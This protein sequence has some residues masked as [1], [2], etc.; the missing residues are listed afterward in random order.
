MLF[1]AFVYLLHSNLV[2]ETNHII[3]D[4]V[5]PPKHSVMGKRAFIGDDFCAGNLLTELFS[6]GTAQPLIIFHM[7]HQNLG[8]NFWNILIY[9]LAG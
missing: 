4:Y 5:R 6:P 8:F 3:F 2:K 7:E 9:I 1:S